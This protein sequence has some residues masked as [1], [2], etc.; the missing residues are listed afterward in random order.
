MFITLINQIRIMDFF[1]FFKIG[2]K[3]NF[4]FFDTIFKILKHIIEFIN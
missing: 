2:K 1:Q 3:N 4:Q